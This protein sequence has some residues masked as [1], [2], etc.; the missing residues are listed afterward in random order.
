MGWRFCLAKSVVSH[1]V[2][3][4]NK[5][6]GALSSAC[7]PWICLLRKAAGVGGR[8]SGSWWRNLVQLLAMTLVYL[9][10]VLKLLPK[11]CAT[12]ISKAK[13]KKSMKQR[14]APRKGEP[15]RDKPGAE[16]HRKNRS[17]VTTWGPSPWGPGERKG[18][19]GGD[20]GEKRGGVGLI[21]TEKLLC[22]NFLLWFWRTSVCAILDWVSLPTARLITKCHFIFSMDKLHLNLTELA[23]AMNHVYSFSV[24]E[25]TIFPSEYLSS[26]LEARLNR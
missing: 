24:F 20:T 9:H 23:L 21:G 7:F 4:Q 16:S 10:C 22:M 3:P 2:T 11:H 12:T 14:Q 19:R 25:H 1:I 6:S 26:H 5:I 15:E 18:K 8:R 13:N 17:L